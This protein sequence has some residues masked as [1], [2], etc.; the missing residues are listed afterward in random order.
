LETLVPAREAEDPGVVVPAAEAADPGA[1][2]LGFSRMRLVS[3]PPLAS[4][5]RPERLCSACRVWLIPLRFV[6]SLLAAGVEVVVLVPDEMPEPPV[7]VAGVVICAVGIAAGVFFNAP[8]AS[9]IFFAASEE[10]EEVAE[11]VGAEVAAFSCS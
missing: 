7:E 1:K 2:G 3:K 9:W 4:A 11:G 8:L 6:E 5:L 10:L